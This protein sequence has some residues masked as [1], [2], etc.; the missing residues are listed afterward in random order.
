[1]SLKN[2]KD[3]N[4]GR[5]KRNKYKSEYRL[6]H[7]AYE[8]RRVWTQEELDLIVAHSI[9]DTELAKQIKRSVGAIQTRRAKLRKENELKRNRRGRPRKEKEQ[10]TAEENYKSDWQKICEKFAKKFGYKL[11][12][13][14]DVSCGVELKD[15]QF[16]H[17]YADEMAELLRRYPNGISNTN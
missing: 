7:G 3:K 14:K 15:G 5:Q 9:P 6:S 1:M 2:Y 17:I 8:Y 4:L 13:V 10:V 12:F 16:R 11:L